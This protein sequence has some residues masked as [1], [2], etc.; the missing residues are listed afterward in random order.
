[1]AVVRQAAVVT[2]AQASLAAWL[3]RSPTE[4]L[5]AEDPGTLSGEARLAL[6][7][8]Q[9]LEQA[10]AHRAQLQAYSAQVRAARAGVAASSSGYMPSFSAFGRYDRDGADTAPFFTD[11]A[12]QNSVSAGL[13]ID[14]KIFSGFGTEAQVSQARAALWRAEL[15]SAQADRDVGA[16]LGRGLAQLE[17]AVQVAALSKANLDLARN[18]LSLA[19]SRFQAG[20]TSTLQVRDAQV[21]L[22]QAEV[23][24]LESRVDVELARA[25]L[26]R[27]MGT[28]GASP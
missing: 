20:D 2:A 6:T 17:S 28:L 5:R 18:G 1:M 25:A 23:G 12:R 16:E 27:S 3:G 26:E 19:T 10:R 7:Y 9:A 24:L 4:P 8:D 14:W 22:T 11:P 15:T 13:S 21:K